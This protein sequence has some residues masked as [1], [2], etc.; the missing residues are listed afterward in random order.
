MNAQHERFLARLAASRQAVFAVAKMQM[1]KGRTV[2]IPPVKFAPTAA[3]AER[4]VDAGDL[5]ITVRRRVE[6]KHLG[7]NFTG[8]EDWPFNG[9][10]LVSNVAAVDRANGDVFAYVSVSN[11]LRCAA[12]VEGSTREFWYPVEKTAKNTGNLERYYA[13]P[14]SFVKFEVMP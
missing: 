7:V 2:E 5:F 14:I 10:I 11:D 3:D 9:E 8:A 6:V 13:C 4:F 12:I 1:M